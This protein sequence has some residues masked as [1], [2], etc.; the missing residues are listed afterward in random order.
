MLV[1]ST[2]ALLFV[3]YICM[4]FSPI[5]SSLSPG[6]FF[7]I[8]F[9]QNEWKWPKQFRKGFKKENRKARERDGISAKSPNP[10][11]NLSYCY[12]SLLTLLITNTEVAR[13][14]FYANLGLFL[15]SQNFSSDIVDTHVGLVLLIKPPPPPPPPSQSQPTCCTECTVQP[16][17]FMRSQLEILVVYVLYC[18]IFTGLI[19]IP[20]VMPEVV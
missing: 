14:W 20:M 19:K 12:P 7:L 10:I 18:T 5:S 11:G 6:V 4:S 13:M 8:L 9:F 2:I 17:H 3:Q 15:F 1:H 16:T